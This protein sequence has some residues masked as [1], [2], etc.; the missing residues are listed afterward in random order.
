M[1]QITCFKQL[2]GRFGLPLAI[3]L[4][5]QVLA[6]LNDT[7]LGYHYFEIFVTLRNVIFISSF[8]TNCECWYNVTEGEI[9]SLEDVDKTMIRRALNLPFS[10][11]VEFLYKP[12]SKVTK[13]PKMSV[14]KSSTQNSGHEG[15]KCHQPNFFQTSSDMSS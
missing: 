6:I 5:S 7:S 3:G 15:I 2:C 13:Q 1:S 10:T 11:P 14:K 12:R 4:M 9:R 8:L